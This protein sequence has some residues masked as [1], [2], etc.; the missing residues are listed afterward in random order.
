MV[1]T[2]PR[3]TVVVLWSEK[4]DYRRQ[5]VIGR[6]AVHGQHR[7]AALGR[8]PAMRRRRPVAMSAHLQRGVVGDILEHGRKVASPS[9]AGRLHKVA[10]V[11]AL[12][13]QPRLKMVAA[14]TAAVRNGAEVDPVPSPFHDLDGV[15]VDGVHE[16]WVRVEKLLVHGDNMHA[17]RVRRAMVGRTPLAD[18][19]RVVGRL[20]KRLPFVH[21]EA[22]EQLLLGVVADGAR[23]GVR[24]ALPVGARRDHEA[25]RA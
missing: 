13:V 2:V 12:A 21:R 6:Q 24:G 4:P 22:F 1:L 19:R 17:R 5:P 15:F 11:Q 23:C 20:P 25:A 10:E 3:G 16:C 14:P 18:D 8:V 7:I 9:I